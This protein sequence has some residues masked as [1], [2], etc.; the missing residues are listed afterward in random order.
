LSQERER[1]RAEREARRGTEGENEGEEA[2]TCM[3]V[4]FVV[5]FCDFIVF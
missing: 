4:F 2:P 3:L 1:E 5:L